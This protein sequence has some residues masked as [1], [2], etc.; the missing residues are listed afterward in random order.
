MRPPKLQPV[1][2]LVGRIQLR[3]RAVIRLHYVCL[4][5]M[6]QVTEGVCCRVSPKHACAPKMCGSCKRNGLQGRSPAARLVA[7]TTSVMAEAMQK[8]SGTPGFRNSATTD[9][10][11]RER[12]SASRNRD[13]PAREPAI[14]AAPTYCSTGTRPSDWPGTR[15]WLLVTCEQAPQAKAWTQYKHCPTKRMWLQI[16]LSAQALAGWLI[17]DRLPGCT[18]ERRL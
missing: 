2:K 16:H 9:S 15:R 5:H 7:E 13:L 10:C 14:A 1:C 17:D 11:G 6:S 4:D 8:P 3:K 12:R 18:W